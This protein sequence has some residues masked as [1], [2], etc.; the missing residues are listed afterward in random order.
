[1]RAV[2]TSVVVRYLTGGDPE[3]AARAK[4]V[5]DAGHVFVSTTVM[6]ETERVLRNVCGFAGKEVATAL[7]AFAG[8]PDVSVEHPVLLAEAFDRVDKGMDFADALHLGSAARCDAML[9]FD[10]RFVATARGAPVRVREP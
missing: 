6:L 2:D 1:M 7:H 5:I 4:G 10:R 8:L 9:T 3:H